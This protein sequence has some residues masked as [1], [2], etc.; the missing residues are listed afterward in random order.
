MRRLEEKEER[1]KATRL[2]AGGLAEPANRADELKRRS[3][4]VL[5]TLQHAANRAKMISS[6]ECALFVHTEQQHWT[7]HY[8]VPLFIS[9][10]IYMASECQRMLSES[11]HTLTKPSNS[12]DF[13]VLGFRPAASVGDAPQRANAQQGFLNGPHGIPNVGNTCLMNALLHCCRQLL[14]T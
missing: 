13:S 6:T 12:V 8:E 9:R 1:E 4:R 10:P 3:W 14:F 11:K 5:V 7:S 2:E